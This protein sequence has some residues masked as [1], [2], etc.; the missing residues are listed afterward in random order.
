MIREVTT[1]SQNNSDNR[2]KYVTEEIMK[3]GALPFD[4]DSC[5]AITYAVQVLSLNA[6]Q[7]V[8]IAFNDDAAVLALQEEKVTL[9]PGPA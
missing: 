6:M 4:A 7:I 2:K 9:Q 1:A 3:M 8:A 5:A